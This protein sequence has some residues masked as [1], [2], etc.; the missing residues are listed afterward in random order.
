MGQRNG[1]VVV[2]SDPLAGSSPD[3]L[4]SAFAIA[5]LGRLGFDVE[6]IVGI[7]R[8]HTLELCREAVA[9]RPEVFV[10]AGDDSLFLT[11]LEVLAHSGIAVGYVPVGRSVSLAVDL[12]IPRDDPS[13][14]ADVVAAGEAHDMDLGVAEFDD[15][16]RV[17]FPSVLSA[18]LA[19]DALL[20][21][22]DRVGSSSRLSYFVGA[23]TGAIRMR[24]YPFRLTFEDGTV[25]EEQAH[26]AAIGNLPTIGH[27]VRLV[28][29]ANAFDGKL[30]LTLIRHTRFAFLHFWHS[31]RMALR[32][33]S[34]VKFMIRHRFTSLRMESP[35][36][37]AVASGVDIGELPVTVSVAPGALRMVLP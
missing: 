22:E 18:D 16:R 15:G 2:L 31:M 36:R 1:R 33:E 28:P 6:H 9:T 30:D 4:K 5:R 20:A 21:A 10:V 32:G 19:A 17:Y 34:P 29:D 14:A 25:L 24:S 27:G 7:N 23:V 12:H 26:V 13:D 11:A 37:R 35:G 8:S 3:A